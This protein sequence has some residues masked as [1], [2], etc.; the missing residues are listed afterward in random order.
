MNNDI[1]N[2]KLRQQNKMFMQKVCEKHEYIEVVLTVSGVNQPSK[3]LQ[4]KFCGKIFN[5]EKL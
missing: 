4:C 2:Y 3:L 5:S 1:L